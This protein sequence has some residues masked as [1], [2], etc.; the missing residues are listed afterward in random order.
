MDALSRARRSPPRDISEE[1]FG[2]AL[3]K[4]GNQNAVAKGRAG[5]KRDKKAALKNEAAAS[6]ESALE[7]F[8]RGAAARETVPSANPR[9]LARRRA[10]KK[11]ALAKVENKALNQD[12]LGVIRIHSGVKD[13][14]IMFDAIRTT[15]NKTLVAPVPDVRDTIENMVHDGRRRSAN[16]PIHSLRVRQSQELLRLQ[17]LF[18]TNPRTASMR[19][20]KDNLPMRQQTDEILQV[21]N[22]GDIY[23]IIVG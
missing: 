20:I 17:E 16:V 7:H 1:L 2:K 14:E 22:S 5:A 13:K 23:S 11:T 12:D 6:K 9:T 19:A 4:R 8:R 15:A 18:E 3:P 21:I 10:R